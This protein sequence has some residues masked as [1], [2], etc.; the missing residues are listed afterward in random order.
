LNERVVLTGIGIVSPIG[1]GRRA[2]WDG[3]L[4]GRSGVVRPGHPWLE[5][6]DIAT[7]IAAPVRDF[8]P[9]TLGLPRRQAALLDRVSW[10]AMA[11]ALEAVED[12]GLGLDDGDRPRLREVDPGRACV[13]VSSGIGGLSTLENSHATWRRTRTRVGARRLGLPMVIPNAPAAEV[14]IRLGARGECKSIATACAAGTM[15]AGDA[16]RL[17][18]DGEAD[19]VFAGGAEALVGD[20]DAFAMLGFD[21]LRAMST[22]NEDPARAS[23]PFDRERDGFVLGEG[24]A[25]LVLER[26]AHA[27]AR[28]AAAYASIVGYAANCDAV[29]MVQLDETGAT[30]ADLARRA[31]RSADRDVRDVE[32]VSAHGTSTIPNDRTEARALRRL[33][34]DRADQVPVTALKSMTGH[35]I[36]A[37]GAMELAALAL[38]LR[39][40]RIAPTINYENPDPDCDVDVVAGGPRAVRPRLALKMSYGFGGHNACLVVEP[41]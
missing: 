31:L 30:I 9:A 39:D 22:R 10:F 27:R 29:S 32:H 17:L 6:T 7:K 40:G 38:A 26:E 19:V 8:D 24:A 21:R 37:S 23:R 18:R 33:L 20:E 16:W 11:A 41:A 4:A 1:I 28:G 14:A 34:G 13:V 35:A 2:F 15:A 36:A 3:A 12:A 25:V 5:E